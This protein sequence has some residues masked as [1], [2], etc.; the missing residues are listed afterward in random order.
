MRGDSA[1]GPGFSHGALGQSAPDPQVLRC[2]SSHA[3]CVRFGSWF[4]YGGV[5]VTEAGAR[6]AGQ[7]ALTRVLARDT[8]D[9]PVGPPLRAGA[10]HCTECSALHAIGI[11]NING[12]RGEGE[13]LQHWR[14]R[15]WSRGCARMQAHAIVRQCAVLASWAMGVRA[16][17]PPLSP[18][19]ACA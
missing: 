2:A 16:P 9:R 3:P 1:S 14:M 7:G 12:V 19:P 8:L 4:V 15:A 17:S 13:G 18:S 6:G 11:Y 5:M 10:P